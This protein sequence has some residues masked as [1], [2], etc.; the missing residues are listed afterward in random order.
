[1]TTSSTARPLPLRMRP[2][3]VVRPV[4]HGARRYWVV[5]DPLAIRYYHLRDEEYALLEMLDGRHSLAD[6]QRQFE[7]RF[8][9]HRIS[10]EQL[11]GFFGML[12][13]EGL[14]LADGPRQAD[15]LLARAATARR[16]AVWQTLANPLAVR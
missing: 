10:V 11:Q 13:R 15:E 14:V 5:K 4:W 2:D 8:A 16:R 1:M 12:H 3:L 7:R 6:V 9:P